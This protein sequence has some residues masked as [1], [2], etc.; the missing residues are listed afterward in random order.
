M[1][2]FNF[3]LLN[4]KKI[5]LF[6]F[7]NTLLSNIYA[8]KISVESILASA[9]YDDRVAGSKQNMTFA[10]GLNYRLPILKKVDLRL[11]IN[12]NL[13]NDTLDG[14][15][16]NEDFYA[17]SI[18]TN[19]FREMRLQRA[20]KP[21]Q[22]NIYTNEKQVFLQQVLLERYQSILSIFYGQ[23]LYEER[24]RL[25]KLLSEKENIVR[26]SLEQGVDIRFKDIM[27]TENDKNALASALLEYENNI[28]FQ[29]QRI[30]QYV[31][32]ADSQEVVID[33]DAFISTDQI[34]KE[35]TTLK[36]NKAFTH[37]LFALR[38]AQ[39]AYSTAEYL[40]EKAQN[41]QFFT[42][43]QVAYN[44]LAYSPIESKKFKALNDVNFRLGLT[45][46]LPANNNLKKS[47]TALQQKEDEQIA[48]LARQSQAKI[49]D[50]QYIKVEN[51]LKSL[52]LNDKNAKE[53]LIK[54]MLDNAKLLA[55]I[56][57]IEVLDLNIAQRKL[58]LRS[59][60]ISADL[61]NEYLR[62]L[63]MTGALS[64]Y[65]NKNFLKG[66]Q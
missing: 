49:V 22:I 33:F 15:W 20:L 38:D 64:V 29:E 63:D 21:A 54:K 51:I 4:M 57:P 14:K 1:I 9:E 56:T 13:T 53:S 61:T 25:K 28:F 48:I 31:K 39:T 3:L 32:I 58:E 41:K 45:I 16:R 52:R 62:L 6:I 65:K 34:E 8:Q 66:I 37:P 19:N 11:G 18:S 26:L 30:R 17:L 55:Q 43:F 10:A 24:S 35:V 2:N 23:K 60:E 5:V 27:D 44:P 47:K 59:I 46:P 7:I 42:F 36:I 40:L 50:I 12:G